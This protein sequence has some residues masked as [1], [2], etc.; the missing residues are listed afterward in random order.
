MST[1]N[2]DP[3]P[4]SEH[5]PRPPYRFNTE[6]AG[7]IPELLR[8][9]DQWVVW[10]Y[11]WQNGRWAKTPYCPFRTGRR[12]SPVDPQCWDTFEAAIRAYRRSFRTGHPFDGIGF[13]FAHGGGL[14]GFDLDGVLTD[15][16]LDP[17]G[18]EIL[19]PL[20]PTYHE[21][22]PSG[23]GT[24]GVVFGELPGKGLNARGLGPDG[25]FGFEEYDTGRFFTMTGERVGDFSGVADRSDVVLDLYRRFK[26]AH[27]DRDDVPSGPPHAGDLELL[28]RA[29]K[30]QNGSAFKALYDRG[31]FPAHHSASEADFWLACRLAFWANRDPDTID[32]LVRQSAL[33]RDKWDESRG[34]TTY[35]RYTIDSAIAATPDVWTPAMPKPKTKPEAPPPAPGPE[36]NGHTKDPLPTIAPPKPAKSPH[37][38]LT[39]LGNAERLVDRHGHDLRY[40]GAWNKWLVWDRR[41]W[42][43][44]ATLKVY[45]HA[46]QTVRSI[47]DEAKH[48]P[49]EDRKKATFAHALRSEKAA[50]VEAMVRLARSEADLVAEPDQ[51]NRHPMLLNCTNGTLDLMTGEL[52]EQRRED[53][54]TQLCPV[55][56]DEA[57]ECPLWL[58]ILDL[59]FRSDAELIAYVRKLCGVCLTGRSDI[60]IL[61]IA[62]GGGGNGKTTHWGTMLDLLGPDYAMK[63]PRNFLTLKRSDGH[64]TELADLYGKRLVLASETN[65]G[66]RVDESLIKDLTGTERI[67]TRRMREDFWEFGPTHKV[68]LYTNHPPV[69]TGTDYALWRRLQLIPY[70]VKIADVVAQVDLTMLDRLKAEYPGIL[71]WCLQ[72]CLEWQMASLNPPKAVAEATS[73]YKRTQDT[74]A[75]FLEHECFVSRENPQIRVRAGQFYDAYKLWCERQGVPALSLTRVGEFISNE[76]FVKDTSN[77]IWY[78]GIGLGQK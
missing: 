37:R 76:G 30:A 8:E 75:Q 35:G 61:P 64:P 22:S 26:P 72:G 73:A 63:A 59:I 33:M 50:R 71:K 53:Y 42:R 31:R 25:R 17:W 36:A 38:R 7:N 39:D 62:Y 44:D 40:V 57:A 20:L 27:Q 70:H 19:G 47:Y 29:R 2:A 21:K 10:R 58:E 14:V 5:T 46:K 3:I 23:N 48:E 15:G 12:A 77:G 52:R 18:Q 56:Y 78:L 6:L 28:E 24:K 60:Q 41:R 68:I 11:E 67:R 16:A 45:R 9:R 4:S 54:L 66:V 74:V 43:V 1:Y 69:V 13:V 55:A 32:R 51:L 34:D 65:E 49:N